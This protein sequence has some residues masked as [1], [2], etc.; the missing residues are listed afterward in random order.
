MPW[1]I[2][3]NDR[4]KMP[5]YK[6]DNGIIAFWCV[7]FTLDRKILFILSFCGLA[8]ARSAPA[9][10]HVLWHSSCKPRHGSY[11]GWKHEPPCPGEEEGYCFAVSLSGEMF[12]SKH[13]WDCGCRHPQM[14]KKKKQNEIVIKWFYSLAESQS[15]QLLWTQTN[16]AQLMTRAVSSSLCVC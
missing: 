7:I 10:N 1:E 8:S 13:R 16:E 12:M 9:W 14:E 3:T 6:K 11:Q 15:D 4:W 5:L 2:S